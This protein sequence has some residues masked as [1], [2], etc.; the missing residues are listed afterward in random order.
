MYPN[1][2]TS[3]MLARDIA[4]QGVDVSFYIP[5]GVHEQVLPTIVDEISLD[6]VS[7]E[8]EV[9]RLSELSSAHEFKYIFFLFLN[10]KAE[11]NADKFATM[12]RNL[13]RYHLIFVLK[14][15]DFWLLHFFV[16]SY[17]LINRWWHW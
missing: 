10:I 3:V 4:S 2:Y 17:S 7:L 13:F 5:E 15:E 16:S 14:A 8:I 1:N 9:K 12:C 6:S 11:K